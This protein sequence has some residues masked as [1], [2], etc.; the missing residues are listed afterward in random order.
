MRETGGDDW[1]IVGGYV[2]TTVPEKET[3]ESGETIIEGV[4][5]QWYTD[6]CRGGDGLQSGLPG[7]QHGT[8][9]HLKH[10]TDET[11]V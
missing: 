6:L 3:G 1:L 10:G 2:K 11:R 7:Y 5:L 9:Y 4:G 8:A